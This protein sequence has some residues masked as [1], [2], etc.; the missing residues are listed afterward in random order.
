[1]LLTLVSTMMLGLFFA[2]TSRINSAFGTSFE[3]SGSKNTIVCLT[4][5]EYRDAYKDVLGKN[6]KVDSL[7]ETR[8]EYVFGMWGLVRLYII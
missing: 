3:E 6:Y 7:E 8:I 2:N 5:R 4:E 1:M